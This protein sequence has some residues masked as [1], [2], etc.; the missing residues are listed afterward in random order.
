MTRIPQ[1]RDYHVRSAIR[2]LTELSGPLGRESC[3]AQRSSSHE[4]ELA[5]LRHVAGHIAQARRKLANEL[6]DEKVSL[7]LR[8]A[9]RRDLI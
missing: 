2:C 9:I 8:A 5:V 4:H 3:L 1:T 6:M 7:Q